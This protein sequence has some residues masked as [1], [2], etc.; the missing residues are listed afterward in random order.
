MGKNIFEEKESAVRS[1]CRRFPVLFTKAQN[2][3][4]YDEDGK[5]YIDFFAGAGALN[6]GHNHP[7]IKKAV[8]EYLESNGVAHALDMYT[9]EK[10]KFLKSFYEDVLEPRGLDYKIM[11]TG[12]TGTN[13]ME[14]AL[15]LARKVKKR[16]NVFALMGCFHGM[17]LASLALT[18]DQCARE[19]AGQPLNNVTHIPA[20]Y[21]IGERESLDYLKM[22]LSD[23][24]SGV[25]KPCA[26]VIETLQA[27]GGIYIM[28]NNYLL[29]VQRICRENDILLIVDDVQVGCGRCGSFF[30]FERAR[31]GSG[32]DFDPDMV[33]L[34]KSI[35]GYGFPMALL[36]LKEEL[37]VWKPAEH[38]G[39]FRGNQ[40]SFV[41]ATAALKLAGELDLNEEANRKGEFVRKF[42]E[43]RILP[44]AEGLEVRGVGLA[45]GI[46]FI[47]IDS[48]GEL[49][50]KI[51]KECFEDGLIF[52]S[53]GRGNAVLKI[54]PPLTIPD[55]VLGT[56]LEIILAAIKKCL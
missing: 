32:E 25:D 18:T 8:I 52:E 49:V 12:P 56:G 21:M 31:S 47:K 48:T 11:F 36:L 24:H 46:D 22:I 23:D 1:Y 54:M 26:F 20:P 29:E 2:A 17:T 10:A 5:E 43:D 44:L 40:L 51:Q 3:Y 55:D 34:S 50:A 38:N 14:A 9:E 16:T 37:D 41:A 19:G 4:L 6:Y 28:S 27:E 30:S 35:G 42:I 39:T 53:V 15:K 13:A 45:Y 7:V 33:T